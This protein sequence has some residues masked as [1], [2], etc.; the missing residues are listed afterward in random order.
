MHAIDYDDI[1]N[2]IEA[3]RTKAGEI[4]RAF[5][6]AIMDS[7]RNLVAFTRTAG[8]PLGTIEAAQGKAYAAASLGMS[9]SDIDPL[10][11]PGAALFG[12]AQAHRHP[13][14]T[15]GGGIP[16]RRNGV[17]HGAVGVSGGSLTEDTAIAAAAV[18]SLEG[19]A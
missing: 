7:G 19:V 10:V 3:A 1:R 2:A 17:L 9:T 16:F 5:S 11:Q 12:M 6:I 13:F 15:F 4:G 8:A 18:A 14:I